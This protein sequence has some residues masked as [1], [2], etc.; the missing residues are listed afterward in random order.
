MVYPRGLSKDQILKALEEASIPS[1]S[2]SETETY[3][4]DEEPGVLFSSCFGG[5]SEGSGRSQ[6]GVPVPV[7]TSQPA[8]TPPPL[9]FTR[10]NQPPGQQHL[11]TR[12]HGALRSPV[13]LTPPVAPCSPS[14]CSASQSFLLHRLSVLP[15]A[16][17]LSSSSL[18]VPL[19]CRAIPLAMSRSFLIRDLLWGRDR[20]DP[21]TQDSAEL[22]LDL[23]TRSSGAQVISAH[24]GQSGSLQTP[25]PG[26]TT[27]APRPQHTSTTGHGVEASDGGESGCSGVWSESVGVGGVCEAGG[28]GTHHH[29]SHTQ[30]LYNRRRESSAKSHL[31]LPPSTRGFKESASW[32]TLPSAPPSPASPSSPT[33]PPTSP[34][35]QPG[36]VRNPSPSAGVGRPPLLPGL[37]R[38]LLGAA[39]AGYLRPEKPLR[40]GEVRRFLPVQGGGRQMYGAVPLVPPQHHHYIWAAQY[41]SLLSSL[42]LQVQRESVL[43]ILM[44]DCSCPTNPSFSHP[45]QL[46][47]SPLTSPPVSHQS[48]PSQP[49]CLPT[50]PQRAGG[51]K[52]LGNEKIPKKRPQE[53]LISRQTLM[54]LENK[55]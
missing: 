47:P 26:V 45:T 44:L 53:S 10:K 22:G 41:S 9:P 39:G 12:S 35:R 38:P 31:S 17:P 5:G 36:H 55:P 21:P 4:D 25:R 8:G 14:S 29:H 7:P 48:F 43:G 51:S 30:D 33:T 50:T 49:S 19:S 24:I 2:E 6:E 27:L 23:T 34:I 40:Y 54:E 46:A 16:S 37:P 18:S 42:P 32:R 15:P 20:R 13:I 1:D 28:H 52:E 11:L 3:S